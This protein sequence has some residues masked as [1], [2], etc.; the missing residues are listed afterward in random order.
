MRAVYAIRDRYA[1]PALLSL[2]LAALVSAPLEGLIASPHL[3]HGSAAG[4]VHVTVRLTL[5]VWLFA[6]TEL[7]WR[8]WLS[9][10]PTLVP[11]GRPPAP[12]PPE[13]S[14]ERPLPGA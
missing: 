10:R 8:R 5:F 12:S 4:L 13:R 11:V 6:G 7:L 1:F 14:M 3:L 2:V 9:K